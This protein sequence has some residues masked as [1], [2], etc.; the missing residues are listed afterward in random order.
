MVLVKIQQALI[1]H[2][3][4]LQRQSAALDGEVI[5][6][7]L[8]GKGNVKFV[9]S[10]PLCFGGEIRHE[11]CAGGTLSHMRELFAEAQIFLGKFT[12][13]VLEDPAV[14]AARGGADVQD[15]LYVQKQHGGRGIRDHAHI[16]YGTGRTGKGGS[17]GLSWFRSGKDIPV[18]PNVLL[19]D[20]NTSRQHNADRF[21]RIPGV[22]HKGFLWEILF[23]RIQTGQHSS[24]LLFRNARKKCGGAKNGKKFFHITSLSLKFQP[25]Y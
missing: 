15:A 9:C 10:E 2:F 13:E 14:V 17:K 3:T 24:K 4:K 19:D 1:S 12:E 16:Q 7:L 20:Q 11:L 5:R 23:S 25:T 6:K 18:A 22:Q 8:S 21:H